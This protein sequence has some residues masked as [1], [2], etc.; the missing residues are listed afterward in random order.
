MKQSTAREYG[1]IV[2][3]TNDQRFDLDR[4]SSA[5]ARYLKD[6]DTMFGKIT[7][8]RKGSMTIAVKNP[9]ERKKFILAAYNGGQRRI[10]D[11][12]NLARNA[13]MNPQIWTDVI[14]FLESAGATKDKTNE[15]TQYVEKVQLYESEFSAKSS[16]D[17]N[18]KQKEPKN[19]KRRCTEGHWVTIDERPVFICD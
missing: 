12:Q 1:L 2:T 6:L 19:R 5:A 15:I 8:V 18:V 10:A 13:G 4:S 7:T 9:A 14:N 17:K 3:K 11:A 16:A